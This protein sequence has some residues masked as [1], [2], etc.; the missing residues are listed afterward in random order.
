MKSNVITYATSF[1]FGAAAG[2]VFA[3]LNAPQ[4]GKKTRAQI[5]HDISNVRSHT[6]KVIT[7][8][9]ARTM[10]KLEDIQDFVKDIG[11]EAIHQTERLKLASQHVVAKPRAILQKVR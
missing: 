4:S 2:A 9:Q 10:D 6:K 3:V 5:Q 7:R 1:I 11:D 8:A